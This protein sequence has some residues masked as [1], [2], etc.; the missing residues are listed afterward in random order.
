ME[1]FFHPFQLRTSH[2]VESP[3]CG[4]IMYIQSKPIFLHMYTVAIVQSLA[5]DCRGCG[6]TGQ[7]NC[8]GLS[9]VGQ[10]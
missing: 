7:N 5:V 3:H 10:D 2:A 9:C 6:R 1:M 4:E 8:V